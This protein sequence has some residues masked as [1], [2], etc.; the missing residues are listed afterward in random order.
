MNFDS[1]TGIQIAMA[2]D[3]PSG[4]GSPSGGG[5]VASPSG[6]STTPPSPAGGGSG[7]SS[8]SP[9]SPSGASPT[10]TP[11]PAPAPS[12]TP[13]PGP[14][15][16]EAPTDDWSA[17]GEPDVEDGDVVPPKPAADAKKL[18]EPKPTADASKT[19]PPA[20]DAQQTPPQPAVAQPGP[21]EATQPQ[22]PTPAEPA[23]IGQQILANIE[24]LATH[25]ATTPEFALSEADKE[26]IDTD[27]HTAIPK[28]MARTFLRAQASAFSQMERVVPAVIQ[29]YMK[30]SAARDTSQGVFYQR[31]PMVNKASH[32]EVVDKIARTYRAENPNASLEK[33]VEDIGPYVLMAA[34]IA[35]NAAPP[36][37]QQAATSH[38]QSSPMARNGGGRAPPPSPFV[39]A[40][41]GGGAQPSAAD[42]NPWDG[43]GA[44]SDEE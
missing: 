39:P 43:Y 3:G 26:A 34:K 5:G 25:L 42:E 35:P 22:I 8:T 13:G 15:E 23:K 4:S 44:A 33:M 36:Q 9:S 38:P 17:L 2:P 12:P 7:G 14:T 19:P 30:V 21:Q 20:A 41:G 24:D 6:G 32:G 29:R 28:L 18:A 31:W 16:T 1:V 11:T 10:P 37:Q 27:V 40:V